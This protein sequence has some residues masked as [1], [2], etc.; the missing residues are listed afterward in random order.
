MAA[1]SNL[2]QSLKSVFG[3]DAFR[4][5]PGEIIE[6]SLG[7]RNALAILPTGGGKSLCYQLPALQRE[8]LTLVVSPMIALMKD[9]VDQLP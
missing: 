8:G 5:L 1:R 7:G 4:P 3:Y 6:A 2:L 9:Q